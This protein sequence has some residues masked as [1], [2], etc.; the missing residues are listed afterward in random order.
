MQK[1]GQNRMMKARSCVKEKKNT[2]KKTLHPA[3]DTNSGSRSAGYIVVRICSS[4]EPML[5]HPAYSPVAASTAGAASTSAAA[6]SRRALVRR[7]QGRRE[8]EPGKSRGAT[9]ISH[10]PDCR[11]RG[12][13][14]HAARPA[15]A[16]AT[17]TGRA[18]RGPP[19]RAGSHGRR[20][21]AQVVRRRRLPVA[22]LDTKPLGV[23]RERPAR[24]EVPRVDELAGRD[25]VVRGHVGDAIVRR[26]AR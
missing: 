10:L 8:S 17:T 23:T 1:K 5:I 24:Q 14:E 15:P 7:S 20:A 6:R 19:E 11:A 2:L 25:R 13:R 26:E 21:V 16:R 22:G 4:K 12:Y 9:T 3:C 18:L